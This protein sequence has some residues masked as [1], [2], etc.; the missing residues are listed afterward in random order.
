MIEVPT[1]LLSGGLSPDVTQRIV[2]RL[3]KC[4]KAA[5]VEHLPDAGH[6]LPITH[7]TEVNACIL[8]HLRRRPAG[9]SG[10]GDDDYEY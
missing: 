10:Y 5:R 2:L 3:A 4:I 1:L 8:N 6:M 7:A 9:N